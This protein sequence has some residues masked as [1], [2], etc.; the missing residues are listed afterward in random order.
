MTSQPGIVWRE[1]APHRSGNRGAAM[2]DVDKR[3]SASGRKTLRYKF[4]AKPFTPRHDPRG[5]AQLANKEQ[6]GHE[7]ERAHASPR[8]KHYDLSETHLAYRTVIGNYR[9]AQRVHV[10]NK[11]VVYRAV[12]RFGG[13]VAA[14]RVPR[15]DVLNDHPWFAERMITQANRLANLDDPRIAR[16]LDFGFTAEER[17]RPYVFF[18]WVD[19]EPLDRL[20]RGLGALTLNH[21]MRVMI[22]TCAALTSL[23]L[24]GLVHGDIKPANLMRIERRH[25]G[26]GIKIVDLD[27]VHGITAPRGPALPL[28]ATTLAYRA[29]ELAFGARPSVSSDI[30]ALG[31]TLYELL[32]GALPF[33]LHALAEAY[34][35]HADWPTAPV[36]HRTFPELRI[37]ESVSLVIARAMDPDRYRRFGSAP[38][39]LDALEH[40]TKRREGRSSTA[41]KRSTCTRTNATRRTRKRPYLLTRRVER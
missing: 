2:N 3:S 26:S 1:R 30:Y 20:L 9:L 27:L 17:P 32:A 28:A 5:D 14:L 16:V 22:E 35:R 25:Q 23:H 19:G 38:A 12:H 36:L 4:I 37:P 6:R 13:R 24:E 11:C 29:P 34:H 31:V 8:A 40:S 18:E 15:R 10:G 33:E 39:L 41:W 21:A 7:P